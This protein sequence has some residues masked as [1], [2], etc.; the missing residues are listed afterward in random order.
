MN[1][2]SAAELKCPPVDI[3]SV[4]D[5]RLRASGEER[6]REMMLA[7]NGDAL[8]A[9]LEQLAADPLYL[10]LIIFEPVLLGG[11]FQHCFMLQ[12]CVFSVSVTTRIVSGGA[13]G[14]TYIYI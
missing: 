6:R 2:H 4:I 1:S 11:R 5:H 3:H 9:P 8:L 7:R 14:R 12:P 10:C 13:T